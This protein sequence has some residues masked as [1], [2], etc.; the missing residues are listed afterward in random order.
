MPFFKITTSPGS[1]ENV[2]ERL[3]KGLTGEGGDLKEELEDSPTDYIGAEEVNIRKRFGS[4]TDRQTMGPTGIPEVTRVIPGPTGTKTVFVEAKHPEALRDFTRH[5]SGVMPGYFGRRG[6][7]KEVAGMPYDYVQEHK[8]VS[9]PYKRLVTNKWT[10]WDERVANAEEAMDW[11]KRLDAM[12]NLKDSIEDVD[13][14][15]DIVINRGK[16]RQKVEFKEFDDKRDKV[17][18]Q[19]EE[20]FPLWADLRNVDLDSL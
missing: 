20:G 17:K 12:D 9:Y 7:I 14:G 19:N 1:E 11:K 5:M 18:Y 13:E 8:D 2:A 16:G 6:T 10:D 4:S 15:S 3:R